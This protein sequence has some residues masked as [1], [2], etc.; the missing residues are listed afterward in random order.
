MAGIMKV[1]I[2]TRKKPSCGFQSLFPQLPE[3]KH[4]VT[5][6]ETFHLNSIICTIFL[7]L[8]KSVQ[9]KKILSIVLMYIHT[10]CSTLLLCIYSCPSFLR[11]HSNASLAST[12]SWPSRFFAGWCCS[13]LEQKH[14]LFLISGRGAK[15]LTGFFSRHYFPP[16]DYTAWCFLYSRWSTELNKVEL[17]WENEFRISQSS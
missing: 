6:H 10:Y 3:Q 2:I 11:R 12:S 17:F 13:G 4:W 15:I 16:P 7:L 5:K 1:F 14:V 8:F 9:R